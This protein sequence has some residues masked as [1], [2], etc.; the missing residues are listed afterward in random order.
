MN[1][2]EV[3]EVLRSLKLCETDE[4]DKNL[5]K[6]SNVTMTIEEFYDKTY[7]E[8]KLIK[9]EIE[10]N[11]MTIIESEDALYDYL[12][13]K[14]I[15]NNYYYIQEYAY[16]LVYSNKHL[17][18]IEKL[19]KEIIDT[20]NFEK[21]EDRYVYS[22][23]LMKALPPN[24]IEKYLIPERIKGLDLTLYDV[25]GFIEIL[26][27][28]KIEEY[29]TSRKIN[30]FNFDNRRIKELIKL[31]EPEKIEKYITPEKVKEYN[32]KSADT[33][34][35]IK[36]LEPKKIEKYLTPEK[37]KEYKI[38][39]SDI[40]YLIKAT[41]NIDKYLFEWQKKR[42]EKGHGIYLENSNL[43]KGSGRIE[44]Y[45]IVGKIEEFNLRTE[46]IKELIKLLEPEKI[47]KYITPKKVKEFKFNSAD[48]MELI[49]LL[50]SEKVEKYI[51]P[52]KVEEYNLN[53]ADIVELIK[54][55]EP[56]KVEKYITP[57]KVKEFKLNSTDTVELI[58]LLEP[59]KIEKYLIPEILNRLNLLNSDN[60]TEIIKKL[61]PEKQEKYILPEQKNLEFGP[62]NIL[63][64]TNKELFPEDTMN[65][66]NELF[67]KNENV[68]LTLDLNFV[69]NNR[70]FN[71]DMFE[72]EQFIRITNYP[73]V[74][75]FL[76]NSYNNKC[77][78]ESIRY[79][80]K[81][82]KNYILSLDKIIKS[83]PKYGDLIN[84]LSLIKENR[85]TDKFVQQLLDVLSDTDNYFDIQNFED[86]SNYYEIKK[87]VCLKILNGNIKENIPKALEG[88]S[89]DKI[90]KF[91]LLEYKFGI[92]LEEAKRLIIRYGA[93]KDKLP[94]NTVSDYIKLL[95]AIIDCEDIKEIINYTINNNLLENQWMGFPCARNAEGQIL[96]MF[97]EMYNKTLY[98]PLENASDKLSIQEKYIDENGKEH[99]IDVFEVKND[100]NMY[101]RSEGAYFGD[102]L[103]KILNFK[104][105]Y[106]STDLRYHGNCG[107]Y[108]GND[109]VSIAPNVDKI[110]VGYEYIP[111]N[112]L[113]SLGTFDL[114]S[115][116]V[117]FNIYDER[118]EFRIPEETINHT[119]N[120]YNEMVL[121]RL[122]VDKNGNLSKLKP[123]YVI[124][125]EKDRK[126]DN[127]CNE[128]R[129]KNPQWIMTKK[130]ASQLNIP[131]VIF[132]M[133]YIQEREI[134]KIETIMNFLKGKEPEEYEE[135]KYN[136]YSIYLPNKLSECEYTKLI[137]QCKEEYG[138]L[139][140]AQLIEKILIKFT[141]NKTGLM[142]NN[143]AFKNYYFT[144]YDL[145]ELINVINSEIDKMPKE[146]SRECL[147]IIKK[148]S[149]KEAVEIS[150]HS[151]REIFLELYSDTVNKMRNTNN[152][153]QQ[154]EMTS[155]EV[156]ERSIGIESSEENKAIYSRARNKASIYKDVNL[157]EQIS[158]KEIIEQS[159][160]LDTLFKKA[161]DVQSKNHSMSNKHGA[162]HIKNVLLISNYLGKRQGLQVGDLE[163]LREA[164]IFHDICHEIDKEFYLKNKISMPEDTHAKDGAEWYLQNNDAHINKE[165]VAFLIEVHEEDNLEEIINIKFP[166]ITLKRKA[167]LI[168]MAHILQDADRLDILRY[169][170]KDPYKQ[171]FDPSR[172]NN[173]KNKE[174][175]CAIIELNIRQEIEKG[176]LY[177]EK[178]FDNDEITT[179]NNL[180]KLYFDK[181]VTYEDVNYSKKN[182]Q[183][184]S[185]D[186]I[187][188]KEKT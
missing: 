90:L 67:D 82:D 153:I 138:S 71:R 110:I 166:N 14:A 186:I 181:Q 19:L 21:Y 66:L 33:V 91:A 96:N 87:E 169:D 158:L 31:L 25:V 40:G 70:L 62:V 159:K 17:E 112:A 157:Y 172:L 36:L 115:H 99:K 147:E 118:S 20:N 83:E 171:R 160:E 113:T 98:K 44:E 11:I 80:L 42:I 72:E 53:S 28:D 168:N 124:W 8:K 126:I 188:E 156:I 79:L 81:N 127:N 76:V 77:L 24:K 182:I 2:N 131:I 54:L 63:Y 73:E 123:S 85:I 100:F 163:I 154:D 29:L 3:D 32:F 43:I 51:T 146:E 6:Y 151:T 143:G 117:N 129:E 108:I 142:F 176:N 94:Q 102:S 178:Y 174:L 23:D 125:I 18:D 97:E 41:G 139:T 39:Q 78:F 152:L 103:D 15:Q 185:V 52:K 22:A 150:F 60:I 133:D 56:E 161:D 120:R 58:K 177:E 167:E 55:L 5:L 134:I 65:I 10:K 12:K 35:L 93:D 47:E 16:L 30:E 88:Y 183:A 128:R 45:L 179:A 95:S 26:G 7:K 27:A 119:R 9:A 13:S 135:Y 130:V 132:D 114:G 187:A 155:K 86:V 104:Q 106:E 136:K 1:K 92:S 4:I 75:K 74:Q 122:I 68:N 48:T 107:S 34:E 46:E 164:A 89:E 149:N 57:E 64:A 148:V 137:E 37:I 109:S 111:K 49:K 116:N 141:N 173:P 50:E 184:K 140:K 69:L 144:D 165:E 59:E 61:Q 105:Y 121:E 180:L 101:I 145:K 170:I 175:I 162:Q 84:N 38:D